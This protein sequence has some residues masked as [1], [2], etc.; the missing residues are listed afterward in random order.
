MNAVFTSQALPGAV[1]PPVVI[2]PLAADEPSDGL[3]ATTARAIGRVALVAAEVATRF[4]R[5]RIPHEPMSWMLAPRRLFGGSTAIEACLHREGTERALALHGLS[6]GLDADPGE[7]DAL[8]C[9]APGDVGGGF[10]EGGDGD[11]AGQGRAVARRFR[12]YSAMV[13]IARGGELVHLFHAS[14]APSA[15]VVR[16]RLRARFGS[17]AA[18]Q[19]DIRVGVDLGCPA[20]AGM[21]PP[22]FRDVVQPGRRVRWSAMSG[23]DV[24]VEHRIPS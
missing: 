13:V 5:E 19:A 15:S 12:L 6:L 22:V 7:V 1:A 24:T 20:T 4:E 21:L 10:W 17:A 16:E 2:D 9:D 3:V 23:L 18:A 11:S 8:L 14:V